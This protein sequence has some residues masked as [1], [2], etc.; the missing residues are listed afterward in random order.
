MNSWFNRTRMLWIG[1]VMLL[2]LMLEVKTDFLK[3]A[4]A[5]SP[6]P[7]ETPSQSQAELPIMD[8]RLVAAHTRFGFQLFSQIAGQNGEPANLMISPTSVAIALTMTYNGANGTTQQAMAEALELQGMSLEE[9]NQAN[10]AL[11]LALENA[12]PDVQL[13]IANSLWGRQ[14]I[15]FSPDFLQ[16]NRDFYSAEINSLD[17]STPDAITTINNWVSRNTQEKIP[18]IIQEINSDTVLFLI[19]ATYFKGN[20]TRHFDPRQ[21]SD[22]PFTL[23]DG[24]QK[25]HPT[26]SQRGRYAYLETDQFQAVSL[27][28]GESE[29]LSMYIFLPHENTDLAS[30]QQT[31]TSENWETWMNQFSR[32][33]GAISLPRFKLEYAT[34]L[35]DAL[36]G[37]GM[38][39]AFDPDEADF[40][41][42][43]EAP[44]FIN[45]VQHKTFIEV[46]EEGTEAAAVTSVEMQVT[47]AAID[48]PFQMNVER[49]FFY[50][51]RDNQTG[52]VLF[53]GSV[54][55]PREG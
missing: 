18:E 10:A 4:I 52:T 33:E 30:F 13:A 50:A 19:N 20:W 16:R 1:G 5:Q 11:E 26:L 2:G 44:L 36:K 24:T 28:Y 47:S 14:D 38:A 12:D 48:S 42:M 51:I 46:N 7:D 9:V 53:M 21:T 39:V 22:R 37:L 8:E 15:S 55:E 23:L 32:R 6:S 27:P 17:F 35:N 3:R 49:P 31:L 54:V 34:Q 45:K 41:S 43:S 25:Q 29:R 40:S